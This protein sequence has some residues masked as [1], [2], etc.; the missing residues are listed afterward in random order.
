MGV[1]IYDES[2]CRVA[3][4]FQ[5]IPKSKSKKTRTVGEVCDDLLETGVEPRIA[6]YKSDD[7]EDCSI[8]FWKLNG[9]WF[10]VEVQEDDLD[11]WSNWKYFGF[12]E[13]RDIDQFKYY[14]VSERLH[15]DMQDDS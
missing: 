12:Y 8:L 5:V 4:S 9:G 6:R 1:I 14:N 3:G 7:G 15:T 11:H 13:I 10:F 2:D